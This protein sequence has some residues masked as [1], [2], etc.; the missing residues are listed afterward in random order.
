M[1]VIIRP[2]YRWAQKYNIKHHHILV[3]WLGLSI[4]I[5]AITIWSAFGISFSSTAQVLSLCVMG[6]SLGLFFYI[7]LLAE[8]ARITGKE[9]KYGDNKNKNL[10]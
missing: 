2:I 10:L 1:L 3:V 8:E 7:L 6:A 4:L 9:K 5:P